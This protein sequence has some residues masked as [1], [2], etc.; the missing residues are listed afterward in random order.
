MKNWQIG[1]LGFFFGLLT[2]GVIIIFASQPQGKPYRL[3]D[4]ATPSPITIHIDGE[5]VQPGVYHLQ[6]GSRIQDAI[7]K[8]GG[9]KQN[10]NIHRINLAQTLSDGIKIYIPSDN[11]PDAQTGTDITPPPAQNLL[12]INQASLTDLIKLP[13]IGTQKAQE[14]IHYRTEHGSFLNKEDIMLVPGI[15]ES[16][17]N[18]IK[19][20]ITIYP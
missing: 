6:P 15:G 2:A 5:V 9:L 12:D 8:A 3:P 11:E 4:P 16:I 20:Y 17:Y 13:G 7:L 10:A 1:I 14:I 19:D 18:L